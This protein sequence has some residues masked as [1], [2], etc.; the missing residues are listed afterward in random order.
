M[1]DHRENINSQNIGTNADQ[2]QARDVAVLQSSDSNPNGDVEANSL[3]DG[4]VLAEPNHEP[5]RR[6]IS[7]PI[8]GILP[9]LARYLRNRISP[10][11]TPEQIAQ[12]SEKKRT[13]L[14]EKTLK[15]EAQVATSRISKSLHELGFSY[16]KKDSA[17]NIT[18]S[19]YIGF[20]FVE[21]TEDAHWLH[22]DMSLWPYG[23]NSDAILQQDVINHIS[24]SVGH[25]VNVKASPEAGIWFVIERA[26]GMMGIPV[27]VPIADMW[28]RMPQTS[29]KLTVPI[30]LTNNR[31]TVYDNLDEMVHTM[32]A[33]QTG[34]GKSTL[35]NGWITTLIMRNSPDELNLV[36]MDMKAGLEFQFFANL[37]HLL[38][39]P[40]VKTDEGIIVDPDEVAPAIFW[41]VNQESKRRLTLIRESGHRDI[42]SYNV[43]RKHPMPRIL[44]IIDEW[45]QAR[46]GSDGDKAELE[47]AKALMLLRAAG[48]HFVIC[49]QT[50]SKQVL[51]VLA[52]SNLPTRVAFGCSEM[53]ASILICGDNSAM[54]LSPAGRCIYKRVS[55]TQ[56]VQVAWISEQHVTEIVNKVKTGQVQDA[57]GQVPSHDVAVDEMLSWA[58]HENGGSLRKT[59]LYSHFAHRG[60]T[61]KEIGDTL[62]DLEGTTV[63]LLGNLYRVD[64]GAGSRSR[65]LV[66]MS[67]QDT[68]TEKESIDVEVSL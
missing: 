2:L 32:V 19:R 21:S 65:R 46:L 37:P 28:T 68:G 13:A 10:P 38:K 56:P 29:T 52:R 63:E 8:R 47:L 11:P 43:R 22:V 49:T 44:V 60:I 35:V 18:K 14:L 4:P 57:I 34:G 41:L 48:I 17:G 31:K 64:P 67:D 40:G 5:Y 16:V 61:Q 59:E 66:A 39:I 30:G 51:N 6:R 53:S 9:K 7:N 1:V 42:K 33:G 26:S 3:I 50:P 45:A 15:G 54:G 12:M 62:S 55:G 24:R 27:H 20:D 25:K 23:V 36:L 58:L